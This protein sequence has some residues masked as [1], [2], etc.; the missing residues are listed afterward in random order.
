M[1]AALLVV[2]VSLGQLQRGREPGVGGRILVGQRQE[3]IREGRGTMA[4][5]GQEIGMLGVLRASLGQRGD[6]RHEAGAQTGRDGRGAAAAGDRLRGASLRRS[7]R[8]SGHGTGSIGVSLTRTIVGPPDARRAAACQASERGERGTGAPAPPTDERCRR[9]S[10]GIR[11]RR[12]GFGVRRR[13]GAS[14]SRPVTV[15]RRDRC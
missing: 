1:R 11:R 5:P 12:E 3:P 2:G 8:G 13:V 10:G 4:G 7:R 14:S 15:Q 9:G 6:H